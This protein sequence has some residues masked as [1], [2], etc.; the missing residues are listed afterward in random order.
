[1]PEP[2]VLALGGGQIFMEPDRPGIASYLLEMTGKTS[3]GI[4]WIGTAR[5]DLE[6]H[7]DMFY[8]T[9]ERLDCEPS[10]LPLF[11]RTPDVETYV[12]SQDIIF[13]GGGNTKSMLAVWREWQLN[14]ILRNAW[15]AGIVLSGL[16]AGAICWFEQGVTDSWA[17]ELRAINCLGFIRLCRNPLNSV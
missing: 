13:V 4:G 3:P 1:M 14:V 7:R 9:F 2:Q 15:Q 6:R 17:N 8:S 16:S 5:G 12:M 11:E 10:H